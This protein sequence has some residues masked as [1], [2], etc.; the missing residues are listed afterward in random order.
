MRND[1]ERAGAWG[2]CG[3]KRLTGRIATLPRGE[4]LVAAC[5]SEGAAEQWPG[6]GRRR[7]GGGNLRAARVLGD[8][9]CG[10][11]DKNARAWAVLIRRPQG[12]LGV[13]AR[14]AARWRPSRTRVRAR[15][16]R[17]GGRRA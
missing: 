14:G 4:A 12:C 13:W 6:D 1:G 16:G 9:G 17:G 15:V 10:L 7:G 3:E 5:G 8:G 2:K 11:R